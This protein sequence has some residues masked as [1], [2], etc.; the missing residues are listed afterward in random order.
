MGGR[1]KSSNGRLISMPKEERQKKERRKK[2]KN[3]RSNVEQQAHDLFD[4]QGN[5]HYESVLQAQSVNQNHH[6]VCGTISGENDLINS[7]W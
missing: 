5:V 6:N 7:V 3:V 1:Q 2:V 4:I